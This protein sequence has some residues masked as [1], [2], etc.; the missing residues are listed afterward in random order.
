VNLFLACEIP[1]GT[2]L[3]SSSSVA[4]GLIKSL[5][6]ACGLHFSRSEIAELA[7]FIE[8]D[9][10]GSPIGKQDQFAAAF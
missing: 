2:G 1:P 9:K 4:V 10:L 6:T 8:I 5:S 7:S 3:G